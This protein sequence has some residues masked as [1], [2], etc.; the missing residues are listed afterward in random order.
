MTI[1]GQVKHAH[2]GLLIQIKN[3]LDAEQQAK[4]LEIR[5][6]KGR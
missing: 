5:D 1:E 4:L 3:Q 2:L 6:T